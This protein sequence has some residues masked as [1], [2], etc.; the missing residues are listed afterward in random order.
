MLDLMLLTLDWNILAETCYIFK[1]TA[2]PLFG[3]IMGGGRGG[4][5]V[6]ADL[7]YMSD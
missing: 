4:G 6:Q 2:T 1:S 5:G 7:C 3:R